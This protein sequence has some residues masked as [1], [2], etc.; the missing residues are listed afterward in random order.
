MRSDSVPV[1]RDI[2]ISS[3]SASFLTRGSVDAS[4]SSRLAHPTI[5]VDARA[6]ITADMLFEQRTISFSF[7]LPVFRLRQKKEGAIPCRGSGEA[8]GCPVRTTERRC[9]Q[10]AHSPLR[11]GSYRLNSYIPPVAKTM[12]RTQSFKL[13][14]A[15]YSK[16]SAFCG[17]YS[18]KIRTANLRLRAF[19]RGKGRPLLYPILPPRGEISR[20][21]FH[22]RSR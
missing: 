8:V 2:C 16:T 22:R 9:A 21:I 13:S 14:I 10:G 1:A 3:C 11:S 6:A 18:A 12:R 7:L 5:T 15:N 4:L 17:S 20:G 19:F